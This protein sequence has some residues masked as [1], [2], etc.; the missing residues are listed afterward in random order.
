MTEPLR[1]DAQRFLAPTIFMAY[2]QAAT[3]AANQLVP[4]LAPEVAA[5]LGVSTALLGVYS[6]LIWTTAALVSLP[7]GQL[8]DRFGGARLAQATIVLAC[9]A[10]L[11]ATIGWLPAFAAGAI[12]LGACWSLQGPAGARVMIRI[13]PPKHRALLFSVRQTGVQFGLMCASLALPALAAALGWR[14]A[15]IAVAVVLATLGVLLRPLVRGVDDGTAADAAARARPSIRAGFALVARERALRCL[16]TGTFAFSGMLFCVNGFF[17]VYAVGE[18]GLTLGVAAGLLALSQFGSIVGRLV[19]GALADRWVAPLR[20]LVALGLGMAAAAVA[21]A[22][23]PRGGSALLLAPVALALGL[24]AGGWNGVLLAEVAR[25]APAMAGLVT[26]TVQ[27]A[28]Y[29]GLVVGPLLLAALGAAWSFAAGYVGV[30]VLVAT[31]SLTMVPCAFAP[32]E[33]A[34]G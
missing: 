2:A 15:A 27:V 10:L 6:V 4:V 16:A 30:A 11:L 9:I 1:S 13:V 7:A 32:A 26:G 5:S 21:L 29:V 20:L 31:A 25:R 18:L 34:R 8:A 19:C 28:G 14:G 33:G 3:A 17:V 23:F 24:T 12:L 22:A